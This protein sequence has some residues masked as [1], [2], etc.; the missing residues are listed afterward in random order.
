[1]S[2]LGGPTLKKLIIINRQ[3]FLVVYLYGPYLYCV[4]KST[5][6]CFLNGRKK[7]ANFLTITENI[8][9]SLKRKKKTNISF[10]MSWHRVAFILLFTSRLTVLTNYLCALHTTLR[11]TEPMI[12]ITLYELNFLLVRN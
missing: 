9:K 1:M 12:Q 4:P 7:G 6:N 2:S 11:Y 3:F 5:E 10:L 8:K